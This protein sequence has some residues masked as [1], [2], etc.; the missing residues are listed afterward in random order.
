[1]KPIALVS[2]PTLAARFPSFQL[3][4]LKPT[5][6]RAGFEVEA[7]S[8]FLRFGERIG[9]RLNEALAN[10]YPCMV[11]EWIWA[12]SAFGEFGD[13]SEYLRRYRSNLDGICA[14][15]G[16][17]IEDIL[18]VREQETSGFLDWALREIDWSRYGLVGFTVVFQQMVASLALAK[19]L[20]REHPELPIIFGGAT[21]EDDIALEIMTNNPQVDF[22]HCGD[23][24]ISLPEVVSRVYSGEPM[25]GIRGMLWRDGG[26]VVYEGRAANFGDLDLAPTPDF[27]EYF[28]TRA[29]SGYDR[30]PGRREAMLPIET[31]R[32]CW[33]GMKNHCTFCGLNRAGMEFRAKK[34]EKVL[35]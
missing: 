8:L 11:G 17:T 14:E 19:E 15:A 34:P 12:R 26:N 29:G 22:I 6:E 18:A 1:M 30:Y 4:L 25:K 31:A 32:G 10:V 23:A 9:W 5:L 13:T 7:L 27:D 20:K 33:Y 2:M 28:H 16:C 24:D 3:G 35:E 21:F